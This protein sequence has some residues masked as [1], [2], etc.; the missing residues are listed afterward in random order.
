MLVLDDICTSGSSITGSVSRIREELPEA[1]TIGFA[2]GYTPFYVESTTYATPEFPTIYGLANDISQTMSKLLDEAWPS[3]DV[4]ESPFVGCAGTVHVRGCHRADWAGC[5]NVWSKKEAA[6][7]KKCRACRAF[8]A[9][10]RF[11]FD[12]VEE[13]IHHV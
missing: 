13:Q 7:L 8:A 12:R 3:T 9:L 10:P 1:K 5:V 4:G 6:D 2:F 11:V